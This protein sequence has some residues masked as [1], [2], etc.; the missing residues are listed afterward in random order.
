MIPIICQNT[1]IPKPFSGTFESFQGHPSPT[2]RVRHT[3][4]YDARG[5]D[6]H[7]PCPLHDIYSV[8]SNPRTKS[9]HPLLGTP[10][11]FKPHISP[12]R[13]MWT[14]K[15]GTKRNEWRNNHQR[16]MDRSVPLRDSSTKGCRVG[17]WPLRRG[18][19]TPHENQS[20]YGIGIYRSGHTC[21]HVPANRR[22]RFHSTY[23]RTKGP[24]W[25]KLQ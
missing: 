12:N 23:I 10:R 4:Q 7:V 15:I 16:T 21:N 11:P 17:C 22:L 18:G 3:A 5:N 14:P 6:H 20:L 9:H 8:V 25:R 13:R 2:P 1:A 24:V 19:G